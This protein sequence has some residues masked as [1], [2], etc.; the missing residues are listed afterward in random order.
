MPLTLWWS[1]WILRDLFSL[2]YSVMSCRIKAHS[3]MRRAKQ[4][5]NPRVIHFYLRLNQPQTFWLSLSS[6]LSINVVNRIFPPQVSL[7][8]LILITTWESIFSI[9]GRMKFMNQGKSLDFKKNSTSRRYSRYSKSV[10][11]LTH[12]EET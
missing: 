3:I 12:Q 10:T 1:Q 6:W 11:K 9:W 2:P 8:D 4:M 7:W 5:F